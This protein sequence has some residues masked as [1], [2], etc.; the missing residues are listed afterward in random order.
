[1]LEPGSLIWTNTTVTSSK[2]PA[3]LGTNVTFTASVFP[4]TFPTLNGTVTF[5]DGTT[6]LATL[7]LN[8]ADRAAYST[9]SLALGSHAITATYNGTSAFATSV[10][11]TLT[12]VIQ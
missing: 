2:N 4:N 5:R 10:S 8:V 3:P 1:V 12:Q 9:T 7:P 6:V 11:A